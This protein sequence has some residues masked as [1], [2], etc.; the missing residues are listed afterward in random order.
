MERRQAAR[1]ATRGLPRATSGA[2][3]QR[4]RGFLLPSESST[5]FFTFRLVLTSTEKLA[6]GLADSLRV[7]DRTVSAYK[8][9]ESVHNDLCFLAEV[10]KEFLLRY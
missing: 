4:R 10:S 1:E 2:A 3:T 8:P 7:Q 9:L 5:V 6:D